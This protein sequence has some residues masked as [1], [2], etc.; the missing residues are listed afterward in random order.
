MKTRNNNA[1][2]LYI[3]KKDLKARYFKGVRESDISRNYLH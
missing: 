3:A 1:K 2:K